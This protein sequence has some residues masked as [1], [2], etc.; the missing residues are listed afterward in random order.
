VSGE[1]ERDVPAAG[2]QRSVAAVTRRL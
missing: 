1:P 2:V